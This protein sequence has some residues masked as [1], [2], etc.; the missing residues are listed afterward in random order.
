MLALET[1]A[2]LRSSEGAAALAAAAG[3]DLGG[4]SLLR[5]LSR[6]RRQLTPAR[7]AAVLEQA[8]LRRRAA[9]KFGLASQMLFT[10]DG[11]EQA[12]GETV[13]EH[14]AG[15][16]AGCARIADCCCGIGGDLLALARRARVEA[17]DRDPVRLGCAEHNASI[18]GLSGRISFHLADVTAVDVTAAGQ[19]RVDAIFFDPGRRA[20]GRRIFDL[21]SYQPPVSLI[22]RWRSFVPSIGVKIA[23]GVAHEDVIWDCEQEFVAE[24]QD[25]KECL[26]WFGPLATTARRATLLPGGATLIQGSTPP[27]D[28]AEEPSIWLYDPSPAVTRAGLVWELAALIGA[29]QLDPEL[30]YLTGSEYVATP[31]ARA[32]RVDEWMPFNL[33][34]LRARLR[35]LG[36]GRVIVRRRGSPVDPEIL[37]HR[38]RRDG[39]EGR[40]L[41]LTRLNG[42]SIVVICREGG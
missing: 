3:V 19:S 13:S 11:L 6:L 4:A 12:T 36:V 33:K 8:D 10:A 40:S 37:E 24:G 22:E 21:D 5:E 26:L 31:F 41:F 17:Y 14:S 34:R 1:L 9:T 27:P 42:R 39:P 7:A 2:F 25:L 29:R 16:Y 18:Y 23:P 32:Y 30:A 15:R 20:G 28:R 35:A 38:L